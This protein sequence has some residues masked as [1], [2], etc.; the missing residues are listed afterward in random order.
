MSQLSM[1]KQQAKKPKTE[2]SSVLCYP[3]TM[4]QS[5][6]LLGEIHFLEGKVAFKLKNK[7]KTRLWEEHVQP[8]KEF[9]RPASM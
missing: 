8:E 3:E 4:K 7:T 9:H 1:S 2:H 5:K 6:H